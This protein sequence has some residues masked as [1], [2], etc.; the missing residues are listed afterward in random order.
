VPGRK[1]LN[2]LLKNYLQS[3]DDMR[4]EPAHAWREVDD[5]RVWAVHYQNP[6]ALGRSKTEKSC[7]FWIA[8][9]EAM[10][11]WAGLLNDWLVDEIE[12]GCVTHTGDCVFAIRSTKA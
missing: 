2:L 5:D 3:L 1:R 11:R 4:G 9:Y 8:S 6:Y 7:H 12:C 10:L